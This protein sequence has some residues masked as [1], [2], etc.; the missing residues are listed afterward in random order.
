[1][2]VDTDV[3]IWHLRGYATA[4]R[5]LDQLENLAI[6]A[7]TYMEL[8]QGM[9]NRTE[10]V[11]LQKSLSMRNVEKLPLT[12]EITG[13]AVQLMEE[14]SLSHGMQMGDALIAATALKHERTVLTGNVKHFRYIDRLRLETFNPVES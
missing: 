7:V 12:P 2:L 4:A 1:M 13:Q 14:F 9:R 11:A 3:M 5:K 6:S 8:L 10:M